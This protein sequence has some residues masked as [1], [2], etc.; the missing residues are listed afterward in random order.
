MMGQGF[1]GPPPA[2]IGGIARKVAFASLFRA[3]AYAHFL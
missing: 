3:E 2:D 1:L